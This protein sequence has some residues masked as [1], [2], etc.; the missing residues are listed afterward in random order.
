MYDTRTVNK[1]ITDKLNK[2]ENYLKILELND[3][4]IS[5]R[6]QL[7][8]LRGDR[9]VLKEMLEDELTEDEILFVFPKE[10]SVKNTS[11]G[12]TKKEI[13]LRVL[14]GEKLSEVA[15]ALY[16]DREVKDRNYLSYRH[17]LECEKDGLIKIVEKASAKNDYSTVKIEK[18]V[19]F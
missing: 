10:T 14:A 11:K 16:P 17:L 15:A 18:V 4:E 2:S 1:E 9:A 19:D 7:I 3:K 13:A 12:T 5:L 8:N 6:K